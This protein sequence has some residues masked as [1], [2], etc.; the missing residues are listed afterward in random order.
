[1]A[2]YTTNNNPKFE[3]T[4]KSTI[5]F[6]Q[7]K[8][9]LRVYLHLLRESVPRARQTPETETHRRKNLP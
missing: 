9:R 1:M 7:K 6:E 5:R 4:A 2:K 3:I 8:A